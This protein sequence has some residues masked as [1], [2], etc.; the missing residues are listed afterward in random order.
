M[1]LGLWLAKGPARSNNGAM[2]IALFGGSFDPPHVAHQL[3]CVYA[4]LTQPIDEVWMV[5]CYQHPFD[6]RSA[7]FAHRV[8]LCERAVATLPGVRVCTIEADL[9]A[10][11]YTLLTLRA[12][13]A[14]HPE[15]EFAIMIGADLLGERERWY[16][17]EELSREAAFVV[18]GR[19][20]SGREVDEQ[21]I[22][23]PEV[24]STRVRSCLQEGQRPSGLVSRAVLAYIDEHGLYRGR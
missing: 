11:S 12:L 4:L 8:A 19:T 21:S 3:A 1:A 6:K 5:P 13:R 23:L 22:D 24:S 17:W 18:L 14:R 16:G 20:G 2:R 15:H 7:P 10:P 9:P